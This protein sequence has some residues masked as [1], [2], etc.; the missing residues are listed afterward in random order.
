VGGR[1]PQKPSGQTLSDTGDLKGSISSAFGKDF[2]QV[3]PERSFGAAV[4]AKIHQFGF[5]KTVPVKEHKRTV[6]Q[7]FGVNLA[8]ALIQTVKAHSR[9][10]VMP[11]RPY[12]GFSASD[13][14]AIH[15]IL[16]DH[17]RAGAAGAAA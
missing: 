11:A 9:K 15:E 8:E 3:G 5:N 6:E 4:Y 2:A 17:M 13:R 16:A 14:Q 7:A 10:M 1:G 12:L